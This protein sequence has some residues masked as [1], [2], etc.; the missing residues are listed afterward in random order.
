MQR[1]LDIDF[2]RSQFPGL[3]NGWTFFDNAGGSQILKPAVDRMTSF[4]YDKN[5]QIGGSYDV[6]LQA[7]KALAD[8][9]MAAMLLVN[10]SRP[11]EIVFGGSTTV[12]LQN[13]AK[14]MRSQLKPGDEIIVTIS[15]HESNIGPW[16]GLTDAGIVLKFWPLDTETYVL[17][18]AD[19]APLMTERTKLV[20]VTH[21]S[22]I[23]GSI[24]PIAEI[25]AFVHARGA[26][27]CVD[28]VAYAPHRAIDVQAWDVDYYVFS[29]YKTYGPHYAMMYGK[30]DHLLEL[31][32]LYHFFYGRDKVP[33]KLEPGN[34]N[35]ELAYSLT[36]IVDYLAE[37]GE[38]AGA[39]GSLREKIV[40]AFDVIAKQEN[41][42][43]DRL[44]GYLGSRNDCRIFGERDNARG[45]RIPTISFA[46]EGRNSESICK[47][48]DAHK[49]AI[50]FGD[51]HA[52]RLGDHIGLPQYHGAVRVSMVHYNTLEEVDRLIASLDAILGSN[53]GM[54]SATA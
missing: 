9:R 26:R 6:S 15:D 12:L 7:A 8:G 29:L 53:V 38:R 20:C 17:D 21:V 52:R 25:A 45:S 11:E 33:G 51:F 10:A 50:R 39:S 41:A 22:N 34:A 43:A 13:L 2:A 16:E 14:G 32:P 30:Y 42:L 44:L 40:A 5:V 37:L 49:I 47:A 4:L 31:D 46:F 28:A 19:L 48:M 24:N 23:L 35:Y 3:G 1:P 27:I 36:G 18:M 54:L